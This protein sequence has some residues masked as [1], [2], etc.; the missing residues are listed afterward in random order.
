MQQQSHANEMVP[1]SVASKTIL[2][3][4]ASLIKTNF[5]SLLMRLALE[6]LLRIE[7]H[8]QFLVAL[9]LR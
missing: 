7:M 6:F 4:I 1:N 3:C 8:K 5:L 2:S 9:F